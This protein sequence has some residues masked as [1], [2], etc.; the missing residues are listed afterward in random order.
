MFDFSKE[1]SFDE[2]A[3]GNKTTKDKTPIKLLNSTAITAR[4]FK[5]KTSSEPKKNKNKIFNPYF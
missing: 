3:V 5:R 2:E 4:S 1:I